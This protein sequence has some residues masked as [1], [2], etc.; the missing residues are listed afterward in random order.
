MWREYVFKADE[1]FVA[2]I[3][4]QHY[5]ICDESPDVQL[6][7]FGGDPFEIKFHDGRVVKTTNLWCQGAIPERFRDRLPDNAVF[8]QGRRLI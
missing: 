3:D 2:R 7:G 5:V 4:G 6:R 1:P 8:L